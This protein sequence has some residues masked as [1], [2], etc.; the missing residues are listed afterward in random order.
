MTNQIIIRDINEKTITEFVLLCIP[1]R[2]RTLPE[3]I[4]GQKL[5]EEWA[6]ET[7]KR[8][9]FIAKGAFYKEKLIGFIQFTP[10]IDDDVLDINC[11]FVPD[12]NWQQKGASG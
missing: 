8:Y 10:N 7:L 11:I 1:E 5:K 12:K 4:E 2:S 6:R 9:G 3:F